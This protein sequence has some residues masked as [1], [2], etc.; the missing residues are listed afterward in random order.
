MEANSASYIK[1]GT[2]LGTLREVKNISGKSQG[3]LREKFLD[4]SVGTLY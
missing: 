1:L 3:N 2:L 4:L